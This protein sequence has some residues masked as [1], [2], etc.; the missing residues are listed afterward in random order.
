M[1]N[2]ETAPFS[3]PRAADGDRGC[4][5]LPIREA[6]PHASDEAHHRSSRPTCRRRQDFC[7]A[8]GAVPILYFI[9]AAGGLYLN[10]HA[11]FAIIAWCANSLFLA[12]LLRTRREAWPP[13]IVTAA[14]ANFAA[15]LLIGNSILATSG[16]VIADL[17][18]ICATAAIFR[19]IN[20]R[21]NWYLSVKNILFITIFSSFAC[22][23]SAAFEFAWIS[24]L[25]S[26][27]ERPTIQARSVTEA[28]D[29]LVVLPLV[30]SWTERSLLSKLN[31]RKLSQIAVLMMASTALSYILWCPIRRFFSWRYRCCCWQPSAAGYWAAALRSSVCRSPFDCSPSAGRPPWSRL[32]ALRVPNY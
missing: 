29:L 10:D 1:T 11:F 4:N 9:A 32:R 7:S 18:E 5:L 20:R 12:I 2:L 31:I 17:F 26:A 8:F 22:L 24:L 23:L 6:R 25:V 19:Q 27:T 21:N 3:R 16:I 30:L 15:H 28:L 14:A 13:S